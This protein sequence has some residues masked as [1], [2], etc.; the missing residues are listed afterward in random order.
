MAA[1]GAVGVGAAWGA[2]TNAV[3]SAP[4]KFSFGFFRF[5]GSP[6][7]LEAFCVKNCV[8]SKSTRVL[9]GSKKAHTCG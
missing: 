1:C 2:A 5:K 4:A 7:L 3:K 8:R 9:K 6:Q